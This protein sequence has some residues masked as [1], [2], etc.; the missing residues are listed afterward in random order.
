MKVD[1]NSQ[2]NNSSFGTVYMPIRKI[3]RILGSDVAD[4]M[5]EKR[6]QIK[7]LAKGCHLR[8]T[9]SSSKG[10]ALFVRF[11]KRWF[12]PSLNGDSVS[13]SSLSYAQKDKPGSTLGDVLLEKLATLKT[14]MLY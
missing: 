5:I 6:P 11:K 1:F 7:K 9:P 3:R 2:S 14:Y 8:L 12:W 10:P 13:L 4:A